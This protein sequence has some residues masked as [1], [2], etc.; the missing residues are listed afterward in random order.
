MDEMCADYKLR[1]ER[2]SA[3]RLDPPSALRERNEAQGQRVRD[4]AVGL[5]ELEGPAQDTEDSRMRHDQ[6]HLRIDV[7]ETREHALHEVRGFFRA[8]G[9][10]AS[11]ARVSRLAFE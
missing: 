11:D 5:N 4:G 1:L 7:R 2:A 10:R 3:H 6:R 8:F 9:A